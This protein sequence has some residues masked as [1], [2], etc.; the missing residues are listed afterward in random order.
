MTNL[1]IFPHVIT[2]YCLGA[3]STSY[4]KNASNLSEIDP[5]N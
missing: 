4:P 5:N 1:I 3:F 2:V